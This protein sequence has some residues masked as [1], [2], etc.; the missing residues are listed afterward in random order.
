M[1][2]EQ[3]KTFLT[4]ADCLNFTKAAERLYLTQPTIS[5]Q[6]RMLE[7]EC[8]MPLFIRTKKEVRLTPAGAIMVMQ[9]KE[10]LN[11]VQ[12]GLDKIC[13]LSNGITGTINIGALE[14]FEA[15]ARLSIILA[16]FGNI[17]PDLILNIRYCSFGIL[18]KGLDQGEFDIIFTLSF[19]KNNFSETLF[20]NL[21]ELKAGIIVSV[22]SQLGHKAELT[23]DDLKDKTVITTNE[24]DSPNRIQDT[25]ILLKPY[26]IQCRNIKYVKNHSSM[27][28]NV[29]AGNGFAVVSDN[30]QSVKNSSLFRFM[31]IE[32]TPDGLYLVYAWKKENYN[33]A[34]AFILNCLSL[35]VDG[36]T[37]CIDDENI[38]EN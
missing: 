15:D 38:A 18:R 26:G 34:L 10:A 3:M 21:Y 12:I 11:A 4:V 29:A 24:M 32:S 37:E 5:R 9:L 31:E 22:H 2:T 35:E 23:V 13:D 16:E 14:G 36:Q 20:Q 8:K 33:P 1:T 17:Y 30:V 6:I 27:L 7:E 19:E 28:L 25:N